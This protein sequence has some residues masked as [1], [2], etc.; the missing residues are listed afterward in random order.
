MDGHG[1]AELQVTPEPDPAGVRLRLAGEM[2]LATA[3]QLTTIIGT[4]PAHLVRHVRLDLA[5]LAFVDAS[6]LA[7]LIE[8]RT[9]IHS[10]GGRLSLENPRPPL[11]RLLQITNLTTLF[12]GETAPVEKR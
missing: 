10:R 5:D 8:T 12:D 3:G 2:D 11:V 6:G 4:L 7:A 9:F 1:P